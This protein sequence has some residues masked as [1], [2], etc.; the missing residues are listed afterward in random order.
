MLTMGYSLEL[1]FF[2]TIWHF[3]R[4]KKQHFSNFAPWEI[5][6]VFPTPKDTGRLQCLCC[7]WNHG[8]SRLSPATRCPSSGPPDFQER[9]EAESRCPWEVWSHV[10]GVTKVAGSLTL[11]IQHFPY[12]INV[13]HICLRNN[14]CHI[15]FIIH[16]AYMHLLIFP[17]LIFALLG[18]CVKFHTNL[19]V[20]S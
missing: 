12:F 16:N 20:H 19:E 4:W 10:T 9:L 18:I 17:V 7:D 5:I 3:I 15:F 13:S 14:Y 1:Y 6:R 8:L 11:E 2:H